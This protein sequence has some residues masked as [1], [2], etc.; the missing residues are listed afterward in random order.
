MMMMVMRRVAQAEQNRPAVQPG[1][2][3][4]SLDSFW[5]SSICT[6]SAIS[7]NGIRQYVKCG[8]GNLP[9]IVQ[10]RSS[11]TMMIVTKTVLG[12]VSELR[13]LQPDV[14]PKESSHHLGYRR[15]LAC[16]PNSLDALLQYTMAST[17]STSDK[18]IRK[19]LRLA[20]VHPT[21]VDPVSL[22]ALRNL[23]GADDIAVA[24][25]DPLK[26]EEGNVK[27]EEEEEGEE[28]SVPVPQVGSQQTHI[29]RRLSDLTERKQRAYIHTESTTSAL[30][31]NHDDDNSNNNDDK[32]T[33]ATTAGASAAAVQQ[34]ST[35][36]EKLVLRRLEDQTQ[37]ILKLDRRV[38]ELSW[39][40]RNG[41]PPPREATAVAM[42]PPSNGASSDARRLNRVVDGAAAVGR[43]LLP[44]HHREVRR[45]IRQPLQAGLVGVVP[46]VG[47][48][49]QQQPQPPPDPP[50][51]VVMGGLTALIQYAV[52]IPNRIRESRLGRTV[53]LYHALRRQ[54]VPDV[55]ARFILK[56]L[57]VLAVLVARFSRGHRV[58]RPVAPPD[59]VFWG[60]DLG[61]LW[62]H[63]FHLVAVLGLAAF[64][65]Q[66]GYAGFW[67]MFFVKEDYPARIWNGED[68]DVD[69]ILLQHRQPAGGGP[70]RR[71]A[72]A[73]PLQPHEGAPPEA[74]APGAPR[75]AAAAVPG[76]PREAAAAA[77]APPPRPAP[78]WRDA[79][80]GGQIPRPNVQR[81]Q[82]WPVPIRLIVEIGF[83]LSS[84]VLSIFPMWQPQ[85]APEPHRE[86][87][88]DEEEDDHEQEY[89][90]DDDDDDDDNR[91]EA[92]QL[93]TVRPPR[94][95]AEYE[96]DDEEENEGLEPEDAD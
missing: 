8:T 6:S 21:D 69:A 23:Y 62:A 10:S 86:P 1:H 73:A 51:P 53:R 40:V 78:A 29:E 36:F 33:D 96:D 43:D 84:F 26:E 48:H 2:Q 81:Q 35:N 22:N 59:I 38:E 87:D 11:M 7:V 30:E 93:P 79:L 68:V 71:P 50:A 16:G 32:E 42:A 18:H 24:E 14:I 19:L 25:D 64:F 58:H 37:L 15:T 56:M 54:Q 44:P 72:P 80:L 90:D 91:Y 52:D 67:Y 5:S 31:D 82:D 13:I 55:D 88:D 61:L 89:D 74:P 12:P 63:R 75:V 4:P 65:V 85:A 17:S 70:Q 95:P 83:L 34:S 46:A 41:Q 92:G 27:G 76:P 45:P 66:S 28:D 9:A 60:I 57:I 3:D 20:G 94:D 39:I 49:Q 77:A 47:A